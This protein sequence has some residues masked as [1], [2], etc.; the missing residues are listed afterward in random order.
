MIMSTGWTKWLGVGLWLISGLL[1]FATF[2]PSFGINRWWIQS[3]IF[4]QVH[5]AVLLCITALAAVWLLDTGRRSTLLLLATLFL[6]IVYQA[7]RLLPYTPLARPEAQAAASC[8]AENRVRVL[9]LNVLKGNARTG[10]VLDL[11]RASDPDLFLALETDPAW[12]RA[13]QPLRSSYPN[14][15]D[16]VRTNYWG[17]MLFSRLPLADAKV[18]YLVD[19]YVPSIRTRVRLPSGA[20]PVFYGLHPKPPL[21]GNKVALGDSELIVAA[22][23]IRK[24]APAAILAGDLND[25]PWS[26][27]T[28]LF[29]EVSGMRDPRV[30]RGIFPTYKTHA[31]L[32][33][34]PIDHIFASRAFSVIGFEKL[35]NVG[36]DHFPVLASFCHRPQIDAARH[37]MHDR[38]PRRAGQV[39]DARQQ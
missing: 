25:V 31:P 8:P 14:V 9:V 34:W 1:I 28:Q 18:R 6:C 17:M 22:R 30:G 4:P 3:L 27:T 13:L 10:P 19:G 11:V 32:L 21:S 36:S 38:L 35:P 5:F 24:E 15:V 7:F 20:E 39:I 16:A 23:E 33:S 2:L 12:A 29:Q 26:P 37:A